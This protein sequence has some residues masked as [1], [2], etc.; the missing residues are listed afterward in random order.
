[1]SLGVLRFG[2]TFGK[3]YRPLRFAFL[4]LL[5][6]EN[7]QL[8]GEGQIAHKIPLARGLTDVLVEPTEG[9]ERVSH[10][11]ALL[12]PDLHPCAQLQPAGL[13]EA[14]EEFSARLLIVGACSDSCLL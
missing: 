8:T 3:K 13:F 4:R 12:Y 5:I 14:P 9:D 6:P 1:V 2:F 11:D 7:Q 10:G